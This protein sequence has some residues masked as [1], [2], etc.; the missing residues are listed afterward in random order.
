MRIL[1]YAL[2]LL[3]T[4]LS[5]AAAQ[6]ALSA[7]SADSVDSF[8]RATM[9]SRQIPGLG[10]AIVRDGQIVFERYYGIANLETGTP[11][12][13]SSVFELASVTKQFTAAAVM[14]LVQDGKVQLDAP[15]S[16][17]VADTPPAWAGIT[18]RRL[19]S[20]TAGL[21]VDAIVGHDGSALLNIRTA[22]VFD[23]LR[24]QRLVA[25]PGTRF[26]YSDA[27][28][29]LLG[30]VIEAVT[31]HSYREFMQHRLFDPVGMTATSILDRAR[32][33]KGRVSVYTLRGGNLANW[34]RDW[35]YEL[36]SF[37][38]V[39]S[40][41]DDVVKWDRSLRTHTLLT[42]QSLNTMW[43]PA[44]LNDSTTVSPPYGFGWYL[45]E[46]NGHRVAEHP[47]A[48]G[49]FLLHVIDEPL[50]IVVLTNLDGATGPSGA[51]IAHGL[52]TMMDH[53]LT[54]APR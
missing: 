32:V 52:A 20:H 24:Q 40:T 45:V 41:V 19:L 38:G 33:L 39:F 27:G 50:S 8:I 36:P 35:Q 11:V 12:G 10:V 34:R 5:D 30:M 1:S 44:R 43:S 26:A 37:F 47:G 14:L 31:G 17:Y 18:I 23:M 21:P 46:S 53:R 3:A 54:F 4:W 51:V 7:A 25:E 9:A 22:Q 2:F 16:T 15:I 42:E 13:P 49:T 28:Y 48:S 6:G 29:F